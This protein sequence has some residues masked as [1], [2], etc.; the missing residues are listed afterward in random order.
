[1]NIPLTISQ[2]NNFI[3]QKHSLDE[4][5]VKFLSNLKLTLMG[6]ED[7]LIKKDTKEAPE[8]QSLLR[9]VGM[10]SF[11]NA[12]YIFK[13]KHSDNLNKSILDE[14]KTFAGAKTD[15]SARTKSSIGLKI[16]KKG[17]QIDALKL[18]ENSLKVEQNIALKAHE[19]LQKETSK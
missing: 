19:I 10:S 7:D 13:T 12:Y 17:L 8:V 5:T 15:A 3:S 9:S 11:V 1:M 14:M 18:I 2:I 6:I 16:F 4:E